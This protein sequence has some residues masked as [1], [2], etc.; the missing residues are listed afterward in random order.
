MTII[1]NFST[2]F[3]TTLIV[4]FSSISGFLIGNFGTLKSISPPPKTQPLEISPIIKFTKFEDDLIYFETI[5]DI[6]VLW[7][8]KN[9]IINKESGKIPLGQIPTKNDL[10]LK[11]FT[12]IG[13]AKTKKFYPTYTY[14]ARGTSVVYRR[15]FQ[16]KQAALD[17][18]FIA[19]K[20][21]K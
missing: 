10:K 17:A 15:F 12:Y 19:S 16:T 20:L 21:V 2:D 7:S 11:E 6:Q 14:P 13:N 3:K 1:T 8:G 5:G 18:G 9:K 4:L